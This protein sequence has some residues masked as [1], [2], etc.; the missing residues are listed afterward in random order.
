MNETHIQG[1]RHHSSRE[2]G[3]PKKKTLGERKAESSGGKG[4]FQADLGGG[5]GGA[6]VGRSN[7]DSK[8]T[9]WGRVRAPSSFNGILKRRVLSLYNT[10]TVIKVLGPTAEVGAVGVAMVI[11][12]M[13]IDD[14]VR[15]CGSSCLA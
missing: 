11:L 1:R 2:S 3:F 13:L 6:P 14:D 4:R 5:G 7:G 15:P 9:F 12:I 10:L 8:L